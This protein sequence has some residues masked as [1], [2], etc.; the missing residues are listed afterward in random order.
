MPPNMSKCSSYATP[1]HSH[2]KQLDRSPVIYATPCNLVEYILWIETHCA[3]LPMLKMHYPIK[4]SHL[5]LCK[6]MQKENGHSASKRQ[7]FCDGQIKLIT[8][9]EMITA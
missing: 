9:W 1:T 5:N 7:L 6:F 3:T 2:I 8:W 4:S